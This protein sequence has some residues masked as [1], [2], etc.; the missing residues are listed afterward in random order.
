MLSPK[1]EK[2]LNGQITEENLSSHI[3]LAMASWCENAGLRGSARFFYHH[4]EEEHTHM[5]KIVSFVNEAGG[6]AIIAGVKAPASQYKSLPAV[7]EI[8]SKHER[9]ITEC[10]LKLSES[11]MAVKDYT[12]FNFLQWFVA[13]QHEEEALFKTVLDVIRVGGVEGHGL[14]FVDKEIGKLVEK[15]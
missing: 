11:A 15:K 14:Y 13:E 7:V 3:Y 2:E 6:H 9:Y 12:T 1:I 8:A 10:I 5:M 4:A